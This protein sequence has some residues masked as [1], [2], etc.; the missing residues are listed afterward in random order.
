MTRNAECISFK[1][2]AQS[3]L[4]KLEL[5][6]R[7]GELAARR[8]EQALEVRAIAYMRRARSGVGV[9][10]RVHEELGCG[11][12]G[13]IERRTW[14]MLEEERLATATELRAVRQEYDQSKWKGRWL[15]T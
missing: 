9:E 4:S 13:E 12:E 11:R 14:R 8:A 10:E 3:E 6:Q 2:Q 7:E 15:Q 5:A 1:A